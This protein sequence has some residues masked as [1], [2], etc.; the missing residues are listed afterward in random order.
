MQIVNMLIKKVA[1]SYP[2]VRLS[3]PSELEIHLFLQQDLNCSCYY[4]RF[5]ELQSCKNM[6]SVITDLSLLDPGYINSPH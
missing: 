6:K 2:S 5:S 3:L 4:T 1:S